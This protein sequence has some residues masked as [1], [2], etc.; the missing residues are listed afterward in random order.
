MEEE[1]MPK[2]EKLL[3]FARFID[4]VFAVVQADSQDEAMRIISPIDY[5]PLKLTWSV[6]AINMPFLD[7]LVYVDP[8]SNRLEH[9]PFRKSTEPS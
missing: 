2:I 4:D 6:S 5:S 9:K 3:F 7:L 8:I 1:I